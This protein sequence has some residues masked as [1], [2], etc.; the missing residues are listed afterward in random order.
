MYTVGKARKRFEAIF[1]L[2]YAGGRE[3]PNSFTLQAPDVTR[4]YYAGSVKVLCYKMARR[5]N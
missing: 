5:C 3:T 1:G 4:A 2:S